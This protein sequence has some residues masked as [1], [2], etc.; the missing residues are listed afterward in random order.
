MSDILLT[1]FFVKKLSDILLTDFFIKKLSDILLTDFFIKKLIFEMNFDST[2]DKGPKYAWG[3]QYFIDLFKTRTT[4]YIEELTSKCKPKKIIV[5]LIY[6]PDEK[7][8]GSWAD[9]ILGYLDYNKNPYRL[10]KVIY[11]IYKHATTQIKI[12]GCEVIPCPMF[13]TLDGKNTKDYSQRVEP[14]EQGGDKLAGTF[15]KIAKL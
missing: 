7:T 8:T 14:S 15:I 9:R 12:D 10:Q 6:Y 1:D 2:I 11:Q 5:C 4:E 13:K 3:M